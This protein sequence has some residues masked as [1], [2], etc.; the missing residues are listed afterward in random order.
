MR[1]AARR[2]P[3]ERGLGRD[4]V[5][6]LVATPD[7]LVHARFGDL[8]RF[9]SSGDLLVVN[10]SAT[11]AAAVDGRRGD[12]R[13][14]VVH[15]ST[16]L[17]EEGARGE[18]TPEGGTHGEGTPEGTHG[19]GTPEGGTHGEATLPDGTW[20]IELRERSAVTGRVTDAAPGETVALPAGASLTLLRR[21]PGPAA[22]RMWEASVAAGGDLGAFLS[23][24]GRPIRYSYVPDPWPLAAYQSV[25]A[26]SPGSAEMPSAGRPFTPELVTDLVVAGVVVA[27]ITLHAGVASLEAGEPPLPERFT[28]PEPTARLVNLTRAAGRRVVAVGTTS[29]RALESVADA[30]GTVRA[31]HGWTDLVLGAAHPVRVVDGLVTGWHDP[32][33][34][35]LALLEAVAGPALVQ[36]AYREAERAGYLWHEFGDSCLL[37]PPLPAARPG[38][39]GRR[40]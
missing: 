37:L 40:A 15:L 33:A 11:I 1:L 14:V 30:G 34:S 32:D 16:P 38:R 19:E 13:P 17:A 24:H 7:G 27:P 23:R 39:P 35:H 10:T 8:P 26:R 3:E 6:L 29:T 22:A 36:A 20:L 31:S 2:P 25:F 21:Y 5:R 9:L 28:V 18:G 12:G 4:G